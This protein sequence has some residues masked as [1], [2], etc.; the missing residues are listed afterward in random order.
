MTKAS[1]VILVHLSKYFKSRKIG[2]H[3]ILFNT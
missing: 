3:A 1:I 2:Y